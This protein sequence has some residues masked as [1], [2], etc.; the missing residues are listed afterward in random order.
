MKRIASGFA[1]SCIMFGNTALSACT[2][3]RPVVESGVYN[4]QFAANLGLLLLPL[5]VLLAIGVA[6]YHSDA[7]MAKLR[8]DKGGREWQTH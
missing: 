4:Q 8:K 3:C 5:A 6:L 2:E 7:I 1:A